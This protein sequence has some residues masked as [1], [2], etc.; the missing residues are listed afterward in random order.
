MKMQELYLL[1]L[2][3]CPVE[4][5]VRAVTPLSDDTGC[6][7]HDVVDL[8]RNGRTVV[9]SRRALLRAPREGNCCSHDQTSMRFRAL[10]SVRLPTHLQPQ[11]AHTDAT[12]LQ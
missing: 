6:R 7:L 2:A 9:N 12:P 3:A 1:C 10:L 4:G 8:E 5:R 11:K